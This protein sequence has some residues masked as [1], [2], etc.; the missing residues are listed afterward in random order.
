MSYRILVTGGTGFLGSTLVRTLLEG[1]YH[2]RILRRATSNLSLLG[3]TA[4]EVEHVVGDLQDVES[5]L[6]AMESVDVVFHTAAYIGFGGRKERDRLFQ[7]NVQGTAHV[8]NA[9]LAQ[10]V[11]RLVHTSSIAALGRPERPHAPIDE[12]ATWQPSRANTVYGFSKYLAEKEVYRGIAEGLDAVIVNPALI[13]GPGRRGENTMELVERLQKGRIPAIPTGCTCVVDVED[14]A[15]GHLLAL[16]RGK[17]GERYILGGENLTWKAIL[18]T[19]AEALDVPPPR[20]MLPPGLALLIGA[21]MEGLSWLTGR[22][23][24]ISRETVRTSSQCY[25]YSNQKALNELDW[26]FRPFRETARR[27]A[28]FL[29]E[30]PEHV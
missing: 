30:T 21:C 9:A 2:V 3:K 4:R 17:T 18:H 5:L 10:G 26:S 16:E 1:G 7:T 19:L 8:V 23:P 22:P 25:R 11:Q 24:L 15:T 14:V 20:Y 12:Q 28:T 29:A 6:Q 13:F 27:I